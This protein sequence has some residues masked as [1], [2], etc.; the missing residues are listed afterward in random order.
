MPTKDGSCGLHV[1]S[2][3]STVEL[4]LHDESS[5]LHLIPHFALQCMK[6]AMHAPPPPLDALR[7]STL[8]VTYQNLD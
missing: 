2:T 3:A 1:I 4:K 6:L 7:G 5:L 8:C